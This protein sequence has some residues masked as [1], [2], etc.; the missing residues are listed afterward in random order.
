MDAT[1]LSPNPPDPINL[2][3]ERLGLLV[4]LSQSFNA[5]L[6]LEVV[7]QRV[8]DEIILAMNAE[9]GFVMLKDETGRLRFKTARGMDQQTIDE[10][11]FQVSKGVVEEVARTGVPILTSDALMDPR[12]SGR[13]SVQGLRLR[14]IVSAA[15][16]AYDRIVGVVYLDNRLQAGIFTQEDLAFLVALSSS[17]AIAIENARLYQVAVE[18]GKLE[19]EMQ[20]ARNVQASLLPQEPPQFSGWEFA[21]KWLP[22]RLVAGDYYDFLQLPND[23]MGV[24]IA[25]VTDKGLAAALFMVFSH[26]TFRNAVQRSSTPSQALTRANQVICTESTHGLYVT[27]FYAQINPVLGEVTYVNAGHN[28]AIYFNAAKDAFQLLPATGM[29]LGVD[30]AAVYQEFTLA[31][32]PNDFLI[33]YTD[34]VVDSENPSGELYGMERF[35]SFLWENRTLQVDE[36]QARLVRV[37]DDFRGSAPMFDDIT[38]VFVRR[39][40]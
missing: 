22:A 4:Q 7:L 28:P 40:K 27:L 14:S 2:P 13:E 16:I 35:E 34:G 29:I 1:N 36:L 32:E 33:L 24:L 5:S 30:A 19:K 39:T 21:A 25:D 37:L 3:K 18:K 17:A 6:E 11:R 15:L 12:F 10:P 20:M 9:R 23:E 26:S 38:M 8:M 31:M